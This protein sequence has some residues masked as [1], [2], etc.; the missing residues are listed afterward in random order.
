MSTFNTSGDYLNVQIGAGGRAYAFVD[1]V[2]EAETEGD[3]KRIRQF[4][5]EN[6]HVGIAENGETIT[7]VIETSGEEVPVEAPAAEPEDASDP[8]DDG[9]DDEDEG[10]APD[11]DAAAVEG[12]EVEAEVAVTTDPEPAPKRSRK[13]K[14]E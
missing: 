12:A 5:V 1:G 13:A 9:E 11:P 4:A 6:A 3:A 7:A 2:L 10:D 8:D 14:A